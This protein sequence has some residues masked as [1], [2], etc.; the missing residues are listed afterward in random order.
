MSRTPNQVQDGLFA[1]MMTG[2]AIPTERDTFGGA[3]YRPMAEEWA[4]IEASAESMLPEAD[5]AYAVN[6]LSDYEHVLGPDP[7]GRDLLALSDG[8][9]RAVAS[10]R[11]TR[12]GNLCAGYFVAAG[13]ALGVTL[14]IQEFPMSECGVGVCGDELVA[15]PAHCEFLVTLPA[16][17]SWDSICGEA[18]CGEPMGGFTPNLMEC[19]IRNEAPLFSRPFFSYV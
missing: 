14:T 1:T 11:W 7:C 17:R 5:P 13:A 15:W 12:V 10:Q 19:V 6:L 18:V 8:D 2:W 3:R 9:R 4:A 16:T